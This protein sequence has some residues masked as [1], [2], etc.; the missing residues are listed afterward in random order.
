MWNARQ[1]TQKMPSFDWTVHSGVAVGKP[2]CWEQ[3]SQNTTSG[4]VSL[5]WFMQPLAAH[6]F[7]LSRL[8]ELIC[9]TKFCNSVVAVRFPT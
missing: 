4:H 7:F 9:T 8:R 6:Y 5:S 3:S 2:C 1:A